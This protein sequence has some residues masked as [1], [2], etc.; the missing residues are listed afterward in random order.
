MPECKEV[1][2]SQKI[3]L[4]DVVVIGPLMVAGGVAWSKKRPGAGTILALFG[5]TTV[6]YNGYNYLET[7]KANEPT[8]RTRSRLRRRSARNQNLR[9]FRR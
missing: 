9:K 3:R 4:L 6:L 5:V 2:K 1:D 7:R 8:S